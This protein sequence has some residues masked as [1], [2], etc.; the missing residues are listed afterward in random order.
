MVFCISSG[1]L[2]MSPFSFLFL[3]IR[4]LSLCPL[5]S[6]AKGF[7]ILLI[8]LKKQKRKTK[9]PQNKNKINKKR[10]LVWSI[11]CVVL[12]AFNWLIS[13]LSLIMSWCVLLLG[14]FASFCSR[15]FRCVVK[16]LVCALSRFFFP[17]LESQNTT[18]GNISKRCSNW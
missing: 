11:L 15:S 7:S 13:S 4:K 2:V 1:S 6:L 5:V 10:F 12:F 17:L 16:L 8:F 9:K 14:E 3:L 18:P